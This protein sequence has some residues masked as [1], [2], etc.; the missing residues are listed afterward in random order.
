MKRLLFSVLLLLSLFGAA[1]AQGEPIEIGYVLWDSEIASTH[2]LAAVIQ[3]EL[4]YEVNLV[5]VDV[6][7]MYNGLARGDLD[8]T[9]SV[10]LP[11]AHA[12]Y[13]EEF[14]AD[15]TDLG[16]NL[17]GALLGLVVPAYVAA[18]S[19]EDLNDYI[20]EFNGE[21]IGIDSGAGIMS[22]AEK[23]IE[24]YGLD[25]N[26]ID[27]SDA[28]MIAALDRAIERD[29][30]VIITGWDPHWKWAVYDLKYLA[31]PKGTFGEPGNNHT[32][33]N[34]EFAESAPEDL[35]ALLKGF[36]WTAEDM[37][38]VMLAINQDGLEPWEAARSWLD[39]NQDKVQ[40]WLQ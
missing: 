13:W 22:A 4:G 39:A 10:S 20:A 33:A 1:A 36:H 7:P 32:L 25:Y 6:G 21:I 3:D 8:V 12:H 9:V 16:P 31:D 40:A 26:L 30:W 38:V 2:V 14:G 29:E 18:D 19:I 34:A 37:A 23:V 17:E 35:L 24:A 5:S 11:V 15:L 28:S 27:S